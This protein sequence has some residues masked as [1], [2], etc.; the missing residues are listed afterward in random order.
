MV[1]VGINNLLDY[2]WSEKRREF[3]NY[4]NI[5][6]TVLVATWYLSIE[7]LPL[8]AHNSEFSISLFVAG[9]VTVILLALM[10]M[11]RYYE[12]ILRWALQNQMEVSHDT[13][14]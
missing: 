7:W 5:V 12:K 9:I 1:A 6:I 2:R 10:S 11:V 4:I 3:P 14:I 13:C 8:G